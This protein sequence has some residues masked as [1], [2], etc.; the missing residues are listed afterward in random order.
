MTEC[1]DDVSEKRRRIARVHRSE[2][3]R[4]A[5]TRVEAGEVERNARDAM[6]R[7]LWNVPRLPQDRHRTPARHQY[8][9]S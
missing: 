2:D 4:G 7:A 3:A 5:T 1:P 9:D 6:R 8:R